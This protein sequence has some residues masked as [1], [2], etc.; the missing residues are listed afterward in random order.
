MSHPKKK[1]DK[2][3]ETWNVLASD[4]GQ[5][6]SRYY[7]M[8]VLTEMERNVASAAFNKKTLFTGLKF[9]KETIE[10]LL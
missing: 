5:C 1:A 4:D 6:Q 9:N 10:I 8:T 2:A 7:G 3:S